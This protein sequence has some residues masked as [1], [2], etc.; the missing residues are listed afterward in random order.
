MSTLPKT[1]LVIV[2]VG[3][4][5]HEFHRMIEWMDAWSPKSDVQVMI[6][7]GTSK[8]SES[9]ESRELIPYKELLSL[10]GSA[11]VVV[12]HGGPSTVMDAR[13]CKK[14]PIVLPRNPEFGE[15]VDHH[16]MEFAQH[17]DRN[18]VALVVDSMEQLHEALDRALANPKSMEIDA[19]DGAIE[20]VVE[21]ANVL[22]HL[23]ETAT[24]V[25]AEVDGETGEILSEESMADEV[26]GEESLELN[27]G[28]R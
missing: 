20:G 12:S 27:L 18:N 25:Y 9:W 8:A 11:T 7:R 14:L 28:E 22:D 6:Q 24:P 3:T 1:P 13:Y 5:H 23:L 19:T 15:H 2:S 21:F 4:D 17:L 10:F 26:V 16:Q